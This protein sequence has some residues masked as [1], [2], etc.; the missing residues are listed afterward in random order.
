MGFELPHGGDNSRAERNLRKRWAIEDTTRISIRQCSACVGVRRAR[1]GT[2]L[3]IISLP[4]RGKE[5]YRGH[6]RRSEDFGG[7]IGSV[8]VRCGCCTFLLH[9]L[10]AVDL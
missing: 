5:V 10:V 4:S 1:D 3:L 8:P 9:F 2:E 7:H 6:W